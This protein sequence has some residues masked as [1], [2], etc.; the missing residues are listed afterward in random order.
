VIYISIQ[1]YCLQNNVIIGLILLNVILYLIILTN[2]FIIFFLHD[3]RALKTINEF[4]G[5]FSNN[6]YV[7]LIVVAIL[8][9]AGMPPLLGFFGKFFIVIFFLKKGQ[10][11]L[12]GCFIILNVFVIYFYILNI[13]FLITKSNKSFFFLKNY[14]VYINFNFVCLS[15]LFSI[16]NIFGIFFLNDLVLYVNSLCSFNF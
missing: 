2:I 12:F 10:F 7:I 8:S 6:F 9:M 16:L 13:R 15:I 4:K 11:F 1:K 14:T 5:I 3:T